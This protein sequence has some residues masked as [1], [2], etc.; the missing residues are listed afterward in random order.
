MFGQD[1]RNISGTIKHSLD[2]QAKKL[3]ETKNNISDQWINL[4]HSNWKQVKAYWLYYAA[5]RDFQ[6]YTKNLLAYICTLCA[7]FVT[8][9]IKDIYVF[10]LYSGN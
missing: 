7:Q 10:L 1:C 3:R 9:W 2:I 4:G 8:P 6:A 5:S